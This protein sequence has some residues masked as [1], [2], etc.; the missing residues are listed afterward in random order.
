[1]K[2]MTLSI[3]PVAKAAEVGAASDKV[4]A[5]Q[6][7][8]GRPAS[9]FMLMSVPFPVPPNSLVAFSIGEA[10]TTESMAARVYPIMLAGA[11]VNIIPLLEVPIGG[12]AEA[13]K[14]YRG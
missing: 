6:P 9:A 13:E 5:S 4:G 2:F 10:D 12:G 8:E 3:Y 1:M 14:K 7:R 11:D